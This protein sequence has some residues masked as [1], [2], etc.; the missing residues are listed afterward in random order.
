MS[1]TVRVRHHHAVSNF[2]SSCRAAAAEAKAAAAAAAAIPEHKPPE[3]VTNTPVLREAYYWLQESSMPTKTPD[4][5]TESP[6][7]VRI[8]LASLA[9]L[10][11][12]YVCSAVVGV[13][14]KGIQLVF[15]GLFGE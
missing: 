11:A 12:F 8:Y 13:V 4:G 14:V 1:L 9:I 15:S 5:R 6:G 10:G 3:F 2:M 7:V